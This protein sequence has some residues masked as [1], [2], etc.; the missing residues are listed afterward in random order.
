MF[1]ASVGWLLD[2]EFKNEMRAIYNQKAMCDSHEQTVSIKRHPK[3]GG[4]ELECRLA[5]RLVNTA[6]ETISIPLGIGVDEWF[7]K[8]RSK[9]N[10]FEYQ[11]MHDAKVV[12][13]KKQLASKRIA[14]DRPVVGVKDR[15]VK[16]GPDEYVWVWISYSEF[17]PL[18]SDHNV[19]FAHLTRNPIVTLRYNDGLKAVASFPHETSDN[20]LMNLDDRYEFRG[21]VRSN[22]EILIRWWE[23][24]KFKSWLAH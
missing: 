24:K 20:K 22:Q 17:K 6:G 7:G 1:Q 16:L 13:P 18:N 9:V 23:R 10:S 11:K 2:K 8:Q 19:H 5:R 15:K 12:V 3:S 4:V 14:R 21:L